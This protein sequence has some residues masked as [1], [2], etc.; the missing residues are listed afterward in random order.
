MKK[1]LTILILLGIGGAGFFRGWV[2]LQVP[3]GSYG[4]IRSKTHGTDGGVVRPGEFRWVWY[5]L[6]PANAV[7]QVY[8]LP[9]SE[10]PVAIAGI[11]PSGDVYSTLA[12]LKTDFSYEVRGSFSCTI[13]PDALP[14]LVERR[15]M[16]SQ[17]DLD[18]YIGKISPEIE[19]H[20]RRRLWAYA[21]KEDALTQVMISGSIPELEK[22]L[23]VAFPDTENPVLNL[24]TVK[25]PDF[26]LYREVRGLYERYM[27]DQMRTLDSD[28]DRLTEESVSARRLF[29]ELSR[30]GELLTKYPVL[31]DYLALERGFPLRA[32]A[33]VPDR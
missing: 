1:V 8:T 33:G 7:V 21:E 26:V 20:L 5:A 4:V 12:G 32:E 18:A 23:E 15:N 22:E 14:G 31:L 17:E 9:A 27:A 19:N 13:R 10:F 29:D 24:Q 30:Y 3:P 16:T 2:Q 11:L 28:L 6:I 25:F